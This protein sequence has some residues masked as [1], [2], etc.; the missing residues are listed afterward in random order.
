MALAHLPS[1]ARS[2]AA[3]YRSRISRFSFGLGHLLPGLAGASALRA[4]VAERLQPLARLRGD[5]ARRRNRRPRRQS[6]ERAAERRRYRG[7][8]A[9]A[10]L[11]VA[12]VRLQ[13]VELRARRLDV[14]IAPVGERGELAPSE[15]VPG[16][17]RFGINRR[18]Q[19]EAG[20]LE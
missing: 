11:T 2:T 8:I 15:M 18:V 19:Q 4:D 6:V 3:R 5:S 14:A 20:A 10:V 17:Q 1:P 13:I 16:V 12:R 7:A 9:G